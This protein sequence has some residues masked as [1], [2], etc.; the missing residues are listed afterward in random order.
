MRLELFLKGGD[1]KKLAR[2]GALLR[3]LGVSSVN[4]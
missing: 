4:L 2:Q 3:T 1:R